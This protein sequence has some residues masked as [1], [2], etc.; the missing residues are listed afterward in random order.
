MSR[1]DRILNIVDDNKFAIALSDALNG[2]PTPFEEMTLGEQTAFCVD[3]LE[4]E[5]NN[6]G[7]EQF[8]L[9]SSGD[10]A[11]SVVDSLRRI[12]A[13]QAAELVE[14][15]ILLF[16]AAAPAADRDQR[17]AQMKSLGAA[18]RD[19]WTILT[20]AFFKYPDNLAELLRRYVETN[21]SEFLDLPE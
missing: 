7:F 13:A 3:E 18:A 9:N 10:Y 4:R 16:G 20:K 5:V 12:G 1:I 19:R 17:T 15:A 21:K 14:E 8:F 6:G 2:L 11:Q